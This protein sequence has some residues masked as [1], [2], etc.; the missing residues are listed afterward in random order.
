MAE[1]A[2]I[3]RARL[4]DHVFKR[5]V[6]DEVLRE[7]F[8]GVGIGGVVA[9]HHNLETVVEERLAHAVAIL[10]GG[11]VHPVAV[12]VELIDAERDVDT[13]DCRGGQRVE[14]SFEEV[15][16][17]V[18]H[19]RCLRA[20]ACVGTVEQQVHGLVGA[21]V[22]T[23]GFYLVLYFEVVGRAE[24]ENHIHLLEGAGDVEADIESDHTRVVLRAYRSLDVVGGVEIQGGVHH[25]AVEHNIAPFLDVESLLRHHRR[26]AVAHESF[27][28][29]HAACQTLVAEIIRGVLQLA[30]RLNLGAVLAVGREVYGESGAFGHVERKVNVHGQFLPLERVGRGHGRRIREVDEAHHLLVAVLCEGGLHVGYHKGDVGAGQHVERAADVEVACH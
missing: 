18:A 1:Q 8:V 2:H 29:G 17:R 5:D 26:H 11:G 7:V 25:R 27:V 12:A 21:L 9:S 13:L 14:L 6:G 3:H 24:A 28:E 23:H 19:G 22:G 16:E 20:G 30:C 4:V 10:H 15:V